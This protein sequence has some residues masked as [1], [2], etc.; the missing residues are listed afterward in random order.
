MP[1]FFAQFP[2]FGPRSGFTVLGKSNGGGEGIATTGVVLD[3]KLDLVLALLMP[4]NALVARVMLATG[5]R[6]GDVLALTRA[7]IRPS[8]RV[9]EQKTGK[10]RTVRIPKA[11]CAEILAQAGDVWAFPS[12]VNPDRPRTRQAVWQDIKRAQRACRCRI[13]LGTHTMRKVYAVR[14]M[15]RYHDIGKVQAALLHARPEVTLLYALAD[16]LCGG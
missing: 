7:Q 2:H 16:K 10:A 14:L 13:N 12:P 9:T 4:G 8:V 3:K 6:V 5:L 11:L 1:S 15:A